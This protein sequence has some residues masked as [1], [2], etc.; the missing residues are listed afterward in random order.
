MSITLEL[1]PGEQVVNPSVDQSHPPMSVWTPSTE[2]LLHVTPQP[3][4]VAEDVSTTPPGE[5]LPP[6]GKV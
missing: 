3:Q 6:R 1:V 4:D 2:S 5:P